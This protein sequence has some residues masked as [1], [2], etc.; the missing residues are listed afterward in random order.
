[1]LCICTHVHGSGK[2][3]LLGIEHETLCVLRMYRK[4]TAVIRYVILLFVSNTVCYGYLL[5]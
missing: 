5:L 1:M 2:I 4:D 3:V